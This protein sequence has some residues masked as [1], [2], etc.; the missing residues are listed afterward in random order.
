MK[1]LLL[2]LGALLV[3]GTIVQGK[4]KAVVIPEIMEEVVTIEPH[5]DYIVV[6]DEFKPSG[7]IGIEY[8]AYGNTEGHGDTIRPLSQPIDQWNRGANRYSRLE[9]IFGIQ[10]TEKFRLE[11]RVRDYSSLERDDS[12]KVNVKDGTETRLRVFY[13]HSDLLTSRIKYKNYISED[14]LYEYQLRVTPY[15][16]EGQIIDMFTIA[17]K[18]AYK[19]YKNGTDY[20]NTLGID[21]YLTGN[22]PLGF[23]WANNL[24]LDYNIYNNDILITNEN[25]LKEKNKEFVATWEFYLYNTVP[26][27]IED[28]YSID[29]NFEGGYDPYIATQYKGLNLVERTLRKDKE[30]YSL[31]TSMDISLK[32]DVTNDLTLKTG[33]G[34]EYRNWDIETQS[35][36]KNW[37][38]QP[39]TYVSMNITF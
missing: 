9:T 39:Y 16:N 22:L 12:S 24:Y 30:S 26:L 2:I 13:D 32:Y 3:V 4:E 37:R 25:F 20:R 7:Y 36:A 21:L 38:W 14:E 18:Y 10:G 28:S 33:V 27:Y 6:I 11:G 8:K 29:L 15:I 17:P 35:G 34:A 5:V 19:K 1:K 31:Y 23:T